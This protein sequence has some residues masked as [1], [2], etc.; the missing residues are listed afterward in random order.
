MTLETEI[1]SVRSTS[2]RRCVQR[3]VLSLHCVQLRYHCF[4]RAILFLQG[5]GS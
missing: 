3:Q 4:E 2:N 1:Y 5:L